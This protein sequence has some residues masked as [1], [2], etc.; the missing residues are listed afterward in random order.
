MVAWQ[1]HGRK[2]FSSLRDPSAWAPKAIRLTHTPG[3]LA[4]PATLSVQDTLSEVM[5][6][7]SVLFNKLLTPHWVAA[8][9]EEVAVSLV[10]SHTPNVPLMYLQ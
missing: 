3:E 4:R 1:I 7:G 9:G 5:E 2:C 8:V 6:P 10:S